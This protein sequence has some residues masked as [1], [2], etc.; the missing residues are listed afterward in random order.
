LLHIC[1]GASSLTFNRQETQQL[2]AIVQSIDAGLS[3]N[4]GKYVLKEYG[5]FK[6]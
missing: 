2:N 1:K 3:A 4:A 5:S 6:K